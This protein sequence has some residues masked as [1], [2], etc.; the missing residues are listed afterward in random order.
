MRNENEM[1]R[2]IMIK[3]YIVGICKITIVDSSG[4]HAKER[5]EIIK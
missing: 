1:S 5:R 2:K 3:D 4:L